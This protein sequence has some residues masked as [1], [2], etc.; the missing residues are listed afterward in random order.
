MFGTVKLKLN[1]KEVINEK[2]DEAEADEANQRLL[3]Q[4]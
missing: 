4:Q 3:V 1:E 2:P